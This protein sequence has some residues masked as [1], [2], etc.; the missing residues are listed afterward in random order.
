MPRLILNDD[1]IDERGMNLDIFPGHVTAFVKFLVRVLKIEADIAENIAV[2]YLPP[3]TCY[4]HAMANERIFRGCLA[5]FRQIN[6]H[7]VEDIC[8]ALKFFRPSTPWCMLCNDLALELDS[9]RAWWVMRV[10]ENCPNLVCRRT[11]SWVPPNVCHF[12]WVRMIWVSLAEKYDYSTKTPLPIDLE[13]ITRFIDSL[14]G[15]HPDIQARLNAKQIALPALLAGL[16]EENP[17]RYSNDPQCVLW[18]V[19]KK[20]YG[21]Q[22]LLSDR[23]LDC[24][25]EYARAHLPPVWEPSIPAKILSPKPAVINASLAEWSPP[26]LVVTREDRMGVY[27]GLLKLSSD[28]YRLVLGKLNISATDLPIQQGRREQ[29]LVEHCLQ[30]GTFYDLRKAVKEVV[31]Q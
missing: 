23:I 13:L 21:Q 31:G 11:I 1:M 27:S 28:K 30:K 2:A 7:V 25:A 22:F 9:R 4:A 5:P 8:S 3:G 10:G 12:N 29:S 24:A 18:A 14:D 17:S 6:P 15:L 16:W 20:H 19:S 26:E